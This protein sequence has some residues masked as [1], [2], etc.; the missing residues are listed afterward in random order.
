MNAR[1]WA[2]G[3]LLMYAVVLMV[4]KSWDF[5]DRTLKNMATRGV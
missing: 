4:S 5:P 3:Q 2:P 1:V